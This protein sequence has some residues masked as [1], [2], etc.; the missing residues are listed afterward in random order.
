M[1]IYIY[2]ERERERDCVFA[3]ILGSNKVDSQETEECNF[4]SIHSVLI[5]RSQVRAISRNEFRSVSSTHASAV[6]YHIHNVIDINMNIGMHMRYGVALTSCSQARYDIQDVAGACVDVMCIS[7][8]ATVAYHP[9]A[10]QRAATDLS[11]HLIHILP[12]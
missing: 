8:R 3:F 5:M 9:Y 11:L 12:L 2:I 7:H 6:S 10:G 4:N 1:Y